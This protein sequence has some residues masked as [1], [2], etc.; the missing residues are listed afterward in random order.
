MHPGQRAVYE[1]PARFKWLAAGRRWRKTTLAMRTVLRGAAAGEPM[2][3]AAPTFRQCRIGWGEL[4]Q[5]AGGVATF[6]KGNMEVIVPP[7]NGVIAF[8]SLDS[9]DNARGKTARGVVIDEAGFVGGAAWHEVI[10]PML[11]DCD[12]WALCMGT[13]KG[14]N[15]FWQEHMRAGDFPDSVA[16]QVPTLGVRKE[17]GGL[18]RAPHPMENPEFPF[19][20][21]QRMY[22]TMPERTFEQEFLAAFVDDAGGVFRRVLEAATLQPQAP[23]VGRQ[24]VMGVDWGKSQDFTVISVVDVQAHAMVASDRFNQID[25]AVQRQRLGALAQRY[26]PS[27]ILAESNSMGEPII[28]QLQREGLPVRGFTTTNATK[29][30]IIEGLALAFERQ[31]LRILNDATLIG[32]LQAYEMDKTPSGMV[33]YGAPE[34]MHD[35]CVMSL[36]L[37]WAAASGSAGSYSISEY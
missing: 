13:P 33:R 32:E 6:N 19:E 1:H 11:S 29:A 25:Y 34:G 14:H 36:A 24:Y 23:V 31:E 22:Q 35:D 2:L 27:V 7:G 26:R 37:A 5:A 8:V 20:E 3:W 4:Y 12:G 17:E 16:W 21:A 18:V 28:E 30:Q 15:W 9:P 10:R